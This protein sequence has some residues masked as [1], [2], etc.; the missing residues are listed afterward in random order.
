MNRYAG[1]LWGLLIGDALG[2]PYEFNPPDNLPPM[3]Q[4]EMT[5]PHGFRK[6]YSGVPEGTWSDDGAQA[7][8]LLESLLD[9]DQL[10]LNDFSK[11]WFFGLRKAYGHRT[12]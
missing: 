12:A 7:L 3:E 11:K 8:C 4:L 10:E 2:V 6:T 1:G 5:P 9:C